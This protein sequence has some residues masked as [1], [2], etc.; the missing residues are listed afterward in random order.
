MNAY[1]LSYLVFGVCF[2]VVSFSR[3]NLFSEGPTRPVVGSEATQFQ[4]RAFW[5]LLC[6]FLWPILLLTGLYSAWI[7]RKRRRNDSP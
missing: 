2:G 4:K 5:A 6:T 3:R 1:I 7:L